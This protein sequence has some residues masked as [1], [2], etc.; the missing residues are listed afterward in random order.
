MPGLNKFIEKTGSRLPTPI[1]D[2]ITVN[3]DSIDVTVSLKF[4]FVNSI[5]DDASIDNFIEEMTDGTSPIYV[6]VHAINREANSRL[7]DFNFDNPFAEFSMEPPIGDTI[8]SNYSVIKFGEFEIVD[9]S[10][11]EQT[12][13]LII[14]LTKTARLSP[15]FG[16]L[17][18]EAHPDGYIIAFSSIVDYEEIRWAASTSAEDTFGM[19]GDFS[20]GASSGD[21]GEPFSFEDTFAETFNASEPPD[22]GQWPDSG[23]DFSDGGGNK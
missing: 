12:E 9:K 2:L 5:L 15:Y 6:Y 8:L 13:N 4:N 19:G 16:P 22:S 3:E 14:T 18:E 20:D 17:S 21:F 10:Y 11:D 1:I 7:Q 23:P